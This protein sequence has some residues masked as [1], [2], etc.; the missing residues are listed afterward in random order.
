MPQS[1]WLKSGKKDVEDSTPTQTSGVKALRWRRCRHRGC[2]QASPSGKLVS[3]H[4]HCSHL[5]RANDVFVNGAL[6]LIPL[7]RAFNFVF[8]RH[9]PQR[10]TRRTGSIKQIIVIYWRSSYRVGTPTGNTA[11][12]LPGRFFFNSKWCV[13][14]RYRLGWFISRSKRWRNVNIRQNITESASTPGFSERSTFV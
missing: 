11:H 13:F 8:C 1:H 4:A 12:T 10:T 3:A 7:L 14:L 9:P 5:V 2:A 6:G